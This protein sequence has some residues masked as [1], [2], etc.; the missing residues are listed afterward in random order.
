[1]QEDILELNPGEEI[2]VHVV[3]FSVLGGDDR[4]GVR[5]SLITDDRATHYWDDDR[6]ISDFLNERV[7]ALS[8][9]PTALLWDSYALFG[10]DASWDNI[11]G[12][13]W[14]EGRTV[15]A[16]RETLVAE[17]DALWRLVES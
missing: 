2:V 16:E 12:P 5:T 9:G 3:W 4:A 8:V 13:L 17:L 7:H 14:G 11:P 6:E 15:L 1:M 10:P